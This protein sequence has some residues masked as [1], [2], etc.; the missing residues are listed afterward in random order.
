MDLRQLS[1]V[2]AIA[3]LGSFTQAAD[4]CHVVQS[5]LSHQVSRLETEL[6]AR[7][8]HRT[9]R[10]VRLT[11]AGRALLPAARQCLEAADRARAEVSAATGLVRGRLSVGVI[12]TV[13]A[14]DVPAELTTFHAAFPDVRVRLLMGNSDDLIERVIHADLDLAFLGLPSERT[15]TGLAD[16]VL[17][18]EHHVAVTASSHR[19]ARTNGLSLSMLA[20]EPFV[21]FPLGGPG[22]A[23]TD[24]AFAAAGLSREVMFEVSDPYMMANLIGKKLGV[25]LLP[26]GFASQLDGVVTAV[27]AD[28]PSR[29]EHLV[30]SREAVSPAAAAFLQ[31][32][33]TPPA[34][35]PRAGSGI[36][37]KRVGGGSS[38]ARSMLT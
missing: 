26:A 21:D 11:P 8:F 29:A 6:G 32:L 30:W 20:D 22:R 38:H 28:A 18:R 7:L 4:R 2:V 15:V 35:E 1:Y 17:L 3:D 36:G 23:Q 10:Q 12:P 25:G 24:Q 34:E 9:S 5:A 14:V 27:V 37:R 16:R 13:A 19:L 33:K 31:Q